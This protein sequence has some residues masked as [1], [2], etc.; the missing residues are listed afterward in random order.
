MDTVAA[1]VLSEEG[2]LFYSL[3]LDV[4]IRRWGWR[5]EGGMG[6]K[7]AFALYYIRAPPFLVHAMILFNPLLPF[8]IVLF[9]DPS[10]FVPHHPV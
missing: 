6:D 4:T 7:G 9:K 2:M 10:L 5:V 1:T 3:V 8:P